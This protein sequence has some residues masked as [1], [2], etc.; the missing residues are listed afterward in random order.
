MGTRLRAVPDTPP[1]AI[2]YL[3]Q[4]SYREESI[5]LTLQETAARDYCERM[6]YTVMGV[7]ADPGISGRTWKRP[8]VQRVMNA[9]ETHNAD[10]IVLWR[11][12]RLSRNRKDW[13]IASDRV[14]I[15][16]GRIESAT[17]PNDT[18][19]A[20]RFGRGVMVELAAFESERIGEQWKEVQQNRTDRGLPSGRLPWG[21]RH[22]PDGI[23][24]HPDQAPAIPHLYDMYLNGAGGRD[25]A[26]WLTEHG[27]LTFY[28][29]STWGPNVVTAVLD[30][31]IH[32]GR[33]IRHGD[34]LPGAHAPLVPVETWERY[35]ATR[36]QRANS[37]ATRHR[38]L[39]S[40]ILICNTCQQPMYGISNNS[41]GPNRVYHAYRCRTV[42]A[43]KG[44]GPASVDATIVDPAF[45][46]WLHEYGVD[47]TPTP[48][49]DNTPQ[50]EAERIAREIATIDEQVTQLTI[51]LGAGIIPP[52]AYEAAIG[53]HETR[54]ATL[55]ATLT[56]V[57]DSIRVAPADPRGRARTILETWDIT[58]LDSRRAAI[59]EIVD[60]IVVHHGAG[61]HMDI[62][63]RE[64]LV[65]SK[66]L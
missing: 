9:I 35:R 5:S 41:L 22:T 63:P 33:I 43:M 42:S 53:H 47:T 56:R 36:R 46:E 30:S 64:G 59:R 25:L 3:R 8:A 23:E 45:K 57:E 66:T 40:G 49:V 50:L 38:Y 19:A 24:P 31:P 28:G 37:R 13:A 65:V 62:T 10:V 52:R 2:L 15:A 17:E 55:D 21:W 60:S 48:D 14:D 29:K 16:G 54:R 7:E 1:R 58:P 39:L 18:T 26:R 44:H 6:G 51:Q 34:I 11:W 12:S 20:G 27:Y 32:A 4:S 61:R